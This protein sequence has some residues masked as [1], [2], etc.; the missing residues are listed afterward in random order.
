MYLIPGSEHVLQ[1][2]YITP[3]AIA[4]MLKFAEW[5]QAYLI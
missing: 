3:G 4:F 1:Y 5:W 2:V